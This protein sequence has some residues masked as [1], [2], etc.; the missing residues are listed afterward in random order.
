GHIRSELLKAHPDYQ[1][2]L[3]VPLAQTEA[4]FSVLGNE[5][6]LRVALLNLME[7]GG[8]FSPNHGVSVA[9]LRKK[10]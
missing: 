5:A 9:V 7:N 2:D 10:K 4:D 1:I 3:K 8:K 6:L